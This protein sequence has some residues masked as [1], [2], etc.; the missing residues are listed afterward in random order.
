MILPGP[1]RIY[2]KLLAAISRTFENGE[3]LPFVLVSSD[4]KTLWKE[5]NKATRVA[6][7]NM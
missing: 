4:S 1:F 7:K 3:K 6:V 5:P 2:H